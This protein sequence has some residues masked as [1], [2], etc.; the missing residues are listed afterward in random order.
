M[1]EF[2]RAW[3]WGCLMAIPD[4]RWNALDPD[5]RARAIMLLQPARY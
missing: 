2:L 5:L 1:R 3:L 4:D